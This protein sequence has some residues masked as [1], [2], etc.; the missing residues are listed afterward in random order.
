MNRQHEIVDAAS[1]NVS[2]G[3]KGS[4]R[5]AEKTLRKRLRIYFETSALFRPLF[6]NS[7]CSC[8]F[9]AC[10]YGHVNDDYDGGK[11][12]IPVFRSTSTEDWER[13]AAPRN[14][15]FC[16]KLVNQNDRLP[17]LCCY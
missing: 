7:K 10:R 4:S 1:V 17:F 11:K 15:M 8:Y 2:G 3:A 5:I 6:E 13:K 9:V 12:L 14:N 16:N